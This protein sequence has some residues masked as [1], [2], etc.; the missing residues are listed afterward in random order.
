[1]HLYLHVP[2]CESKCGYCAFYSVTT[3][4]VAARAAYPDLA[5]REWDLLGAA[6]GR[7]ETLYVG[8]GTP[9]LLGTEGFR[10]LAEGLRARGLLDELVEWTV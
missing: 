10:R 5:L 2:F 4:D 9:G 6:P 3:A 7:I 1:M 8:G